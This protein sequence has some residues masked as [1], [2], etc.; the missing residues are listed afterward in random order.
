MCAVYR[1]AVYQQ[2][3]FFCHQ[4]LIRINKIVDTNRFTVYFEAG[5]SMFQQC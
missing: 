2:I 5:I 3:D 1:H 4:L